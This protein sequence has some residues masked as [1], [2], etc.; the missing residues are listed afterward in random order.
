MIDLPPG[1]LEIVRT[2]L[3]HVAPEYDV[4]AFGSR[5]SQRARPFSD[6]DLAII[7]DRPL[8]FEFL[9]QMRDTFS[10]SD[11][12]IKVDLLDWASV[13]EGFREIIRSRYEVIQHGTRETSGFEPA[14]GDHNPEPH[15]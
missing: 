14:N 3:G 10:E 2:I 15:V 13:T 6:L 7:A 5:V 8:D 12:P 9:G 11:L 4:W 1:Q